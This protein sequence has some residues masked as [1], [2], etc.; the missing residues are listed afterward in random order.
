MLMKHGPESQYQHQGQLNYIGFYFTYKIYMYFCVGAGN[1]WQ[2]RFKPAFSPQK[3][4]Y[5]STYLIFLAA[6]P[7][8]FD[9]EASK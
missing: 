1:L 6:N 4:R 2:R 3:Q 8:C 7:T 5:K 9:F